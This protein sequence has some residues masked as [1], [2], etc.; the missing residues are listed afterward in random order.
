M[1]GHL[2][3]RDPMRVSRAPVFDALR[4]CYASE[5]CKNSLGRCRAKQPQYGIIH[6]VRLPWLLAL[7]RHVPEVHPLGE[8]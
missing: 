2:E 8:G 4:P 1:Q 3:W 7:V 6:N 5:R